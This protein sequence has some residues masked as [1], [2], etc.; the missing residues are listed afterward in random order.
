MLLV[1][2]ARAPGVVG[3]R[4]M[5]RG[6]AIL[7]LALSVLLC[8]CPKPTFELHSVRVQGPAPQGVNLQMV[9][10]VN[11][12]YPF[13]VKVRNVR[14][15]V[16]IAGRYRLPPI[17]YDPDQWLGANGT[18]F[19]KVPVMV[20]WPMITP[21]VRTTIGSSELDY[22]V[23]GWAD[24]TAVRMLGIQ[25]N[26]HRIEEHSAVSRAELVGVLSRSVPWP[27]APPP[28]P[29]PGAPPPGAP[30]GWR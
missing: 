29:P 27:F 17:V 12:P 9:M 13:D 30:M 19:V 14:T 5:E 7:I 10:Q 22:R 4:A 24:I 23:I 11:N 16:M 21:L 8:G 25:R 6:L 18:T 28:A 2:G 1:G 26:D 20:P 3:Y 15:R